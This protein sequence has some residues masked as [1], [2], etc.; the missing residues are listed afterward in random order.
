MKIKQ[1]S[2]RQA[3]NYLADT[4]GVGTTFVSGG[5]VASAKGIQAVFL[6]RRGLDGPRWAISIYSGEHAHLVDRINVS[7]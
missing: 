7:E 6:D 1:M 4:Y 3:L 5:H 2:Q